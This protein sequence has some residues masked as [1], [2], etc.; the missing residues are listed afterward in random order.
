ME[1]KAKGELEQDGYYVMKSGG[2]LG[3]FDLVAINKDSVRLIQVK[4]TYKEWTENTYK[5]DI[6]QIKALPVPDICKKE[7]WVWKLRK[8]WDYLAL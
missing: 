1:R 4:S 8:G 5:K 3:V 6:E 2:S 7:L